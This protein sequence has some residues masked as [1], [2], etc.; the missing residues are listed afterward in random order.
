MPYPVAAAR[1]NNFTPPA[2]AAAVYATVFGGTNTYINVGNHATVQNLQ[3]NA[4]TAEGWF[5]CDSGA[6]G[7]RALFGKRALSANGWG[8]RMTNT[9]LTA[10]VNCATTTASST[11]ATNF[12]DGTWHHFAMTFDDA[13]DRRIDLFVDGVEVTYTTQVQGSGAVKDDSA[14]GLY[15]GEDFPSNWPFKGKVG[16][17]RISNVVRYTGSFTPDARNAPPASDANTVRL[18]K[19]DEGTGTNINDT[20]SNALDATMTNGSWVNDP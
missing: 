7:T 6:A 11:K 5:Q 19:M 8:L 14:L 20:S 1:G 15:I 18:F 17:C 9:T 2:A 16:W 12:Q 13:G 10:E 4:F 3:D